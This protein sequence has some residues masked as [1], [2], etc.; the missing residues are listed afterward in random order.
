MYIKNIEETFSKDKLFYCYSE[1]LKKHLENS[2]IR[3][4]YKVSN[5][6]DRSYWIFLKSQKFLD[7]VKTWGK[8]G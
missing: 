8:N 6:T 1:S 5:S 7:V 4:V 2:G 3:C